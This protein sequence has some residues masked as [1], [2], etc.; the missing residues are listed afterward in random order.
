[1]C[2]NKKNNLCDDC[3]FEI[4]TCDGTYDKITWGYE[5]GD[6]NIIGCTSFIPKEDNKNVKS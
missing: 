5:P 6:D 1:M 3:M 2:T 4:P